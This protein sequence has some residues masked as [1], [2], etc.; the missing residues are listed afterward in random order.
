[1]KIVRI[2]ADVL[3]SFLEEIFTAAGCN[4][5]NAAVTAEGVVEADLRGHHIQGTDH[6]YS[7]I[8]ELKAGRINGRAKPRVVRSTAAAAQV[9]GDG[10]T[11]HVGARYATDLAI[12]LAKRNGIA[13]VGLVRAADI[14]M[15]GAYAERIARAGLA[16]M[17]FTNS[18]P[19]RV[20][21]MGGIDPL[22]GT[23]PV[24]F[25]LPVSEGEPVMV[26]FATS[27]SAIGHIRIAS[28][29]DTPIPEG[30]AVDRDG[31]PTT[32]AK[33]ALAGS[34]MPLGG[35]KGYGLG[36]AAALM[37]GPLIGAMLGAELQQTVGKPGVVPE[38]GH[39]FLAIDPAAFGDAAQS[40]QR[41]RRHLDEIKRSRKARGVGEILIPGER[42]F[43]A[44]REA[45]ASGVEIPESVWQHT[46]SIAKDFGVIPP[47][48]L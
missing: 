46:L 12:E 39:L 28:Y 19:T 45:L 14:F 4:A 25:G 16:G 6:I 10:A 47:H 35:A 31:N 17:I 43:R 20:H 40:R 13:G 2:P 44:R 38:R 9:D 29:S 48:L 34:L 22:I 5:E 21:P 11:G 18:V 36:L 33:A 3:R 1:M 26:D 23:N 24:A 27:V 32:S 8:A 41:M 42:S 15:I 30:V 37:S 7:T